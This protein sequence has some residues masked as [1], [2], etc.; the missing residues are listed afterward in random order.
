MTA[1]SD[2]ALW[3][4]ILALGLGTFAVRFSFLGLF[5]RRPLPPWLLRHLRYTGVAVLPALIAPLVLWPAATQ[6]EPDATRLAAAAVTLA[7]GALTKSIVG[8]IVA[9]A[10][11]FAAGLALGL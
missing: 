4:L 8:A 11:T 6:A 5:G 2:A 7:T 1:Y 9:G 10:A 3:G